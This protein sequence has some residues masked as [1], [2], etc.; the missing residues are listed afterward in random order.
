M[1]EFVAEQAA[2]RSENLTWGDMASIVNNT[3]PTG[4]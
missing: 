2:V 4:I 1:A 3:T